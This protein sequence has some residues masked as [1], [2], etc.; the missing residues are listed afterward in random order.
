MAGAKLDLD[1]PVQHVDVQPGGEIRF[2][3][4]FH[5]TLDGSVVDAAT[6]TWPD[7]APG[8]GSVDAGGIVELAGGGFHLRSRD[9]VTHEVVAIATG[10]TAPVCDAAGV[11]SPCLVLRTQPQAT[12]R[13]VTMSDWKQSLKGGITY[14]IVGAPVYAPA[15]RAAANPFVVGALGTV[16]LAVVGAAIIALRRRA[17]S[18]PAGQLRE[19]VAR[20]ERKL[21]RADAALVATLRPAV[22]RTLEAIEEKRVDPSSR[23]GVRVKELLLRV[24][25]RLDETV[26]QAR[27]E[28]EQEA[29]D[30][31]V[32]E[33]ESALEAA[34]EAMDA[35]RHGPV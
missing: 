35:S 32:L 18:S 20:V 10:D 11:A 13:L 23:E 7:G 33:V 22:G 24:E 30:E 6:T 1:R 25:A 15:V 9:P 34:R 5:S 26:E 29:A 2:S 17:K 28:K 19:L 8:G 21:V 31:L 14:E 16:A 3:G 27:A 12:S 4:S